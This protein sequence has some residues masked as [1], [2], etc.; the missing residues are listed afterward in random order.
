MYILNESHELEFISL[1]TCVIY[2]PEIIRWS[3]AIY[4]TKHFQCTIA[5][6]DPTLG[7]YWYMYNVFI[8]YIMWIK[9]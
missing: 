6:S 5:D 2:D 8:D 7:Q 4:S 3:L 9:I 1:N